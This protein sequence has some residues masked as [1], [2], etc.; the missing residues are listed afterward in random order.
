M[1]L[2]PTRRPTVLRSHRPRGTPHVE[3]VEQAV[4]PGRAGGVSVSWRFPSTPPETARSGDAKRRATFEIPAFF[5]A[6]PIPSIAASSGAS[7]GQ[8]GGRVG[9]GGPGAPPPPPSSGAGSSPAVMRT[10]EREG[11]MVTSGSARWAR[12]LALHASAPR[13]L[14]VDASHSGLRHEPAHRHL[15]L[16][17]LVV[18]PPCD[19]RC[20]AA[21]PGF[22]WFVGRARDPG[23]RSR[24]SPSFAARTLMPSTPTHTPPRPARQR[25]A[26]PIYELCSYEVV[27][28]ACRL[29][30][31]GSRT[32]PRAVP[33]ARHRRRRVGT[34][35]HL[36]CPRVVGPTTRAPRRAWATFG[37]IQWPR[38]R[39]VG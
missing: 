15:D 17:Y 30:T 1:L 34:V 29:C 31:P 4:G 36:T 9:D 32:T 14:D 24:P 35:I 8:R 38:P 10:R 28:A 26:R 25:G 23:P 20:L 11:E 16:R 21:G 19:F 13:P 6:T 2:T 27:P 3:S 39:G 37:R 7:H 18:A 33:E 5:I 22:R 12:G